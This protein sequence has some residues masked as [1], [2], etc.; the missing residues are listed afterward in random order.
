MAVLWVSCRNMGFRV[1]GEVEVDSQSDSNGLAC[2]V[3][4]GPLDEIDEDLVG[5][6]LLS[7]LVA[8]LLALRLGAIT[9]VLTMLVADQKSAPNWFKTLT[10]EVPRLGAS[11]S[12]AYG[13]HMKS[14][15]DWTILKDAKASE[16]LHTS[17]YFAVKK[18]DSGLTR[19]IFNG[20][21]LSHRCPVPEPVNLIDIH[22]LINR[23]L[24]YGSEGKKSRRFFVVMGDFRHWFHQLP[25]PI[26][27]QRL[28]GMKYKKTFYSWRT[29]PMGW[30]WSPVCAQAAAWGFLAYRE[31]TESRLLNEE[32]L[33]GGMSL[34]RW[35]GTPNGGW[36][37]VYYDNFLIVTPKEEEAAA[38]SA[39]ITTNAQRLHVVIKPGS[40][41]VLSDDEVRQTGF[42]YLGVHFQTVAEPYDSAPAIKRN[43][44]E[45]GTADLLVADEEPRPS[46]EQG[47]ATLEEPS[48]TNSSRSGVM[49]PKKEP[50]TR[51]HRP[52]YALIVT[53]AKMATW[54]ERCATV[55]EAPGTC[56]EAAS[57]IGRSIFCV[58]CSGQRVQQRVVGRQVVE[59]GR[60]LG[61]ESQQGWDKS[62]SEGGW[63]AV[64]LATRAALAQASQQF[65]FASIRARNRDR[66]R[67]LVACDASEKG[68]GW[69]TFQ[70]QPKGPLIPTSPSVERAGLWSNREIE[71]HIY[72]KELYC[73]CMAIVAV[74]AVFPGAH[75]TLVIDNAAAYHSLENGFTSSRAGT[76]I[77]SEAMRE[78]CAD[79][80]MHVVSEDNPSDCHSRGRYDDLQERVNR[81]SDTWEAHTFGGRVNRAHWFRREDGAGVVRHAPV[82]TGFDECIAGHELDAEAGDDHAA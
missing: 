62:M 73:A 1:Y 75:L 38:W 69:I 58:M 33:Q 6:A 32:A 30:S 39:R 37:T 46:S 22:G 61:I 55:S 20:K 36:V 9:G 19:S 68:Y 17:G 3:S 76:R 27:L 43:R 11:V 60:T 64:L 14:L 63:R 56:R 59:A 10:L 31:G 7:K 21:R 25:A 78:H 34:P 15:K 49:K 47:T 24:A 72:L 79:A 65:E 51:S 40:F 35:V 71:W 77:M 44:G 53:A 23:M 5:G 8:Q 67:L 48:N 80:F 12:P 4:I 2:E 13:A 41:A 16:L 42:T 45:E 74:R 29:L 70:P 28:F 50:L 54:A 18:G 82:D 66:V 26:W 81:L 57:W 52:A